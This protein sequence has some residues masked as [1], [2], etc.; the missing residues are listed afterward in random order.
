MGLVPAS[1]PEVGSTTL[2]VYSPS[3][4]PLKEYLPA[5]SVTAV[6]GLPSLSRTG[7][8]SFLRSATVTPAY[9]ASESLELNE[10]SA[11]L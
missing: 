4:R 6:T 8:P 5:A 9:G 1:G 3:G 2:T 11:S 7:V 10:A